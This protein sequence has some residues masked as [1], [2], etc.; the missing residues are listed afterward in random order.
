MFLIIIW[1]ASTL[2]FFLPRISGKDPIRSKLLQQA[3]TGGA[4]Q[5]GMEEIVKT[6]EAKFGMDKPLYMQY[7]NYLKDI[8]RFDF[9]YSL[10]NYPTSVMDL[11]GAALPWTAGLLLTSTIIAF[12]LGTLLGALLGW[13][14]SPRWIQYL[15][16]PLLIFAA[17]PFFLLGLL[18]IYVFAFQWPIL[19]GLGGYSPGKIPNWS[20]TFA[21]DVFQHSLLPGLAIVLASMGFW[22]LGMRGMMVTAEGEDFMIYAEANGLKS[23]T[24]FF[25]YAVRNALLPQVTGLGLALATIL[26]GGILVEAVFAFPGIGA[27]LNNAI[28]QY[29]FTVVQGII[30]VVVVAVSVATLILDLIYPKLDPRITYTSK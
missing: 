28:L 14:K 18:L 12:T 26:S 3:A 27:V 19:P 25:H 15:L 24:R 10:A 6:Y 22:A 21:L 4:A 11:M 7:Y 8:I 2:N 5:A 30:F 17:I 29:D 1:A 13:P 9:G 20:F 16:P 23:S